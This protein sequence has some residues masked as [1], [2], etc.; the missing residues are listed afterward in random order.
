ML[1]ALAGVALVETG[2]GV[3]EPVVA[4][5]AVNGGGLKTLADDPAGT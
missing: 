5:V 4:G 2:E 3:L 1:G